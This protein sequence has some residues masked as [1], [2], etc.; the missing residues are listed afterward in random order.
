MESNAFFSDTSERFVTEW[1]TDGR[2]KIRVRFRGALHDKLRVS[3]ILQE[4]KEEIE[5]LPVS[6]GRRFRYY[7]C[8]FSAEEAVSWLFLI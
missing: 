1:Q 5:L 2:T 6:G 4:K 7:A 8:T 3:L